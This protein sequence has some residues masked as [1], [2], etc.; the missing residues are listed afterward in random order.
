MPIKPSYVLLSRMLALY[1]LNFIYSTIIFLPVGIAYGLFFHYNV[2]TFIY[3]VISLLMIPILVTSVASIFGYLLGLVAHKI[4]NKN[5]LTVVF[6]LGMI[7]VLLVVGL[8]LGPIISTL[9]ENIHI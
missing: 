8:N 1:V 6:G 9:M 7:A 3:F 4:P 5:F 2:L